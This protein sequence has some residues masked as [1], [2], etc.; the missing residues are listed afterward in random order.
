MNFRTF[1][2]NLLRVLDAMLSLRN[3]TRVGEAIGLSQ[4]AVSSALR[5]LREL[6]GDPLFV[7]EGN[8]LVPTTLALE[9]E[10]P[11]RDALQ[12]LERALSGTG[13]FDP[14]GCTRTFVIGASDFFQEMLM[15]RLAHAVSRAAP[16]ARV[17][18]LPA[19]TALFPAMLASNQLDLVTSIEV[20]P[21]SWIEKHRLFEATN[22]VAVREDHPLLTSVKAGSPMPLDLFCGLPH[23]IFSVTDQMSHFE[24]EALARIGR[25]R[26]VRFSVPGYYGVARVAAQSDL[27]GVIPMAFAGSVG[28]RLGLKIL[29]LPFEPQFIGL[30]AYWRRRDASNRE[31]RWLRHLVV[32]LLSPLNEHERKPAASID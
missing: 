3:T 17:R 14:A 21:P 30:F 28:D 32:D 6:L 10:H 31:L 4:P 20:D 7:R 2:L 29:R 24:D 22:V 12:L 23:V 27:I 16:N 19:P 25:S 1:D 9:I 8:L 18:M 11:V 26:H 13:E 5:R 15:P